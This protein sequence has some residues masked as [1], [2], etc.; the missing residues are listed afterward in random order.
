MEQLEFIISRYSFAIEKETV[1]QWLE[2]INTQYD[3][4]P[5]FHSFPNPFYII[6][7]ASLSTLSLTQSKFF[8]NLT[9]AVIASYADICDMVRVCDDDFNLCRSHIVSLLPGVTSTT[10]QPNPFT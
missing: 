7:Q 5:T 3:H 6:F 4:K 2:Q 8:K 1:C 10:F 9:E